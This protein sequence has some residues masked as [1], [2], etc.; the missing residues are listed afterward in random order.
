MGRK[1][2]KRIRLS[3]IG[4]RRPSI[5]PPRVNDD[6]ITKQ[7]RVK[8]KVNDDDIN[9]VASSL[10]R[11]TNEPEDVSMDVSK[12]LKRKQKKRFKAKPAHLQIDVLRKEVEES[13]EIEKANNA[14]LMKEHKAT[15]LAM[16][17]EH[18]TWKN[19]LLSSIKDLNKIDHCDVPILSADVQKSLDDI[20]EV[21]EKIGVAEIQS[22]LLKKTHLFMKEKAKKQLCEHQKE[23][24]TT[25]YKD[26]DNT[27]TMCATPRQLIRQI[28]R[29]LDN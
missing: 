1:G 7:E 8:P 13:L 14:V 11:Q 5:L 21:F 18:V 10:V 29:P 22:K 25:I 17:S 15:L 3:F 19:E 16:K 2:N 26:M 6:N 23:V 20:N 12:G 4:G 24:N 28:L 27:T 9:V